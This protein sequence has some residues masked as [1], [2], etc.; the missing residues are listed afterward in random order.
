MFWLVFF[1]EKVGIEKRRKISYRK[2]AIA[3]SLPSPYKFVSRLE[4]AQSALSR[5]R[6]LRLR[7][8]D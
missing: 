7:S 2:I 6:F 5:L 3:E 4:E 1:T 8:Q